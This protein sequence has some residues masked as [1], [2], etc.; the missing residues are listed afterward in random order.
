MVGDVFLLNGWLVDLGS[1]EVSRNGETAR[2]EPQ[3]VKV[4][5]YLV[6]HRDT[7]VTRREL[8]DNLWDHAFVGDAALTR[9]IFEIRQAFR[10]DPRSPE[11]IE[12]IP[13]KGFRLLATPSRVPGRTPANRRFAA[14]AAVAIFAV[15]GLVTL[16]YV[17]GSD[18]EH[19]DQPP[20]QAFEYYEAAQIHHTNISRKSNSSAIAMFERAIELHPDYGR[21]Y[22]GLAEA[23]SRQAMYWGGDAVEYANSAAD[24]AVQLEPELARSHN[25]MGLAR[26]LRGEDELA[27]ESFAIARRLDPTYVEPVFNSAELHRRRLDFANAAQLF[28]AVVEMDPENSLAKSHLGF[29]NLRMGDMETAN[30]WIREAIDREPFAQYA[31]TQLA[32]LEMVRGNFAAAIGICETYYELYPTNKMCLHVLG[33]SNLMLGNHEQAMQWFNTLESSFS[34]KDYARLGQ[35]QVLL[36][37]NQP[38]QGLALVE[39]VLQR[40]LIA[41]ESDAADWNTYWMIAA[42]LTLKGDIDDAFVWLD[43]AAQAGRQFYLWDATD[44]VFS[45]LHGDRRFDRYITMT[46]NPKSNN[47]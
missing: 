35:A 20:E 12:T 42:S 1:G 40:A 39:N 34:G 38:D 9:C 4:L 22:A 24:T 31:N 41:A 32:T 27:L 19:Q 30:A 18:S 28:Q 37:T 3:V 26:H 15:T 16:P 44:T 11:V 13:R 8:F 17:R 14:L 2:L 10:D 7:V 36:A 6:E 25:A 29:L 47:Y 43:K 46:R 23:L 21:A 33:A 5:A 45:A